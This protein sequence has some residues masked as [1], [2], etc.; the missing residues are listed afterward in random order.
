MPAMPSVYI[1]SIAGKCPIV[2]ARHATVAAGIYRMSWSKK[3]GAYAT[4]GIRTVPF[5]VSDC[6][7]RQAK[8]FLE[9]KVSSYNNPSSV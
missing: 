9:K 7:L 3:D 8:R 6:F 4:F 2:V 5:S 1:I